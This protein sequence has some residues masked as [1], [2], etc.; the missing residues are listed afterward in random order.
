MRSHAVGGALLALAV[1]AS[2]C[3]STTPTPSP[4]APD[5]ASIT[6]TPAQPRTCE[7]TQIEARAAV[8][9]SSAKIVATCITCSGRF[10]PRS[11]GT[12]PTT[13]VTTLRLVA[14]TPGTF[15]GEIVFTEV[16]TWRFDSPDLPLPMTR[17]TVQVIDPAAPR[18][19]P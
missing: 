11:P 19:C 5:T 2:A 3:D 15:R 13:A 14:A 8:A 10:P 6:L 17:P 9:G 18:S 1:V 12:T 4:T 7:A 16:G